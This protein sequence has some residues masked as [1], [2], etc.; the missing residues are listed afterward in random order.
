MTASC[1][2]YSAA[3]PQRL[4]QPRQSDARSDWSDVQYHQRTRRTADHLSDLASATTSAPGVSLCSSTISSLVLLHNCLEPRRQIRAERAIAKAKRARSMAVYA[5]RPTHRIKE[6]ALRTK[7]SGGVSG[8]DSAHW[9]R[10]L[11]SFGGSS[12][13]LCEAMADMAKR[14][15]TEHMDPVGLEAYTANRLVALDKCP[16]TRPIG[17]GEVPRRIIGKGI[18]VVLKDDVKTCGW[19]TQPMCRTRIRNRGTNSRHDRALFLLTPP[20]LSIT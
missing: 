20:I 3:M 4:A 13:S 5:S 14:L 19:R 1:C 8:G 15:C 2:H 9:K 16:G 17:I 7:G 18:L 6:A 10:L 11:L 12:V